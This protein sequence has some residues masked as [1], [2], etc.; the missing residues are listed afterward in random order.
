MADRYDGRPAAAAGCRRVPPEK[1]KAEIIPNQD[2]GPSLD[3]LNGGSGT[4][5]AERVA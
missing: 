5:A 1:I 2:A 3:S 4:L